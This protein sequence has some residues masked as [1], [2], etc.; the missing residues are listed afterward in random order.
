MDEGRIKEPSTKQ[1]RDNRRA[2]T[3]RVFTE[4]REKERKERLEKAMRL[5]HLRLI[6]HEGSG[7]SH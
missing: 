7:S 5:R 3:D 1:T 2:E 4:L 6:N